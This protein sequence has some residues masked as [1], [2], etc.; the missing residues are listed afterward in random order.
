MCYITTVLGS[1]IQSSRHT[2][3]S[4]VWT[5]LKLTASL[6]EQLSQ[7]I[8]HQALQD[9]TTI[10]DGMNQLSYRKPLLLSAFLK[11]LKAKKIHIS[12]VQSYLIYLFYFMCFQA[13]CL[14]AFAS[15]ILYPS[16]QKQQVLVLL[17]HQLPAL[18][19]PVYF[20]PVYT[21]EFFEKLHVSIFTS[22]SFT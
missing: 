6:R 2:G 1:T 21:V 22:L 8:E 4:N 18:R 14:L 20:F 10:W 17:P 13:S 16:K 15:I 19:L 9:L 3:R 7:N 11:L 5:G 12:S